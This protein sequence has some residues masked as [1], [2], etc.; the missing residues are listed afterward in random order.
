MKP[1]DALTVILAAPGELRVDR[2]PVPSVGPGAVRVAMRACGICGSDLRY[3]AGE[4]PW[5]LHTLGENLVS[6]PNMVLGHEVAGIAT[7][8]GREQRVAI[9]AYR[10]CG[11]CA[12]CRAGRENI[13]ANVQHIGH[14]TGWGAMDYYPGGMAEEFEVWP[15]FAFP[16]PDHV[17]FDEATFLD[18]L[19]VAIHACDRAAVAAGSRV[20]IVGLGPIGMLAAQV[21][22]SRGAATVCGCDTAP[23]PLELA[24]GLGFADLVQSDAERFLRPDAGYDAIIDTVGAAGSVA[25]APS[26]LA[27]GGTLAL[28]SVHPESISLPTVSLSA[29]RTIT[30]AANNRYADFPQAIDLLSRGEVRVAPLVTHR[31]PLAQAAKAFDVMANKEREKAYKIVLHP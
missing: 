11:E 5:A 28:L 21:A 27:P 18:G 24:A 29:E 7:V 2:I 14:A 23:L 8:D 20:A 6:P 12:A 16:I 15:G 10:A 31:F 9:L 13:C 30:S 26:S 25:R 4:N 1:A 17:S 22:R 3:L 19:A